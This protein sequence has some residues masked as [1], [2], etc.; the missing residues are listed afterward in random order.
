MR[1]GRGGS[2]FENDCGGGF[3][4]SS[5]IVSSFRVLCPCFN[6]GCPKNIKL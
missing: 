3:I 1:G 2:G 5:S 6:F 4:V